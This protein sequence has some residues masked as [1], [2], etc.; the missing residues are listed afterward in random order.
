MV[1]SIDLSVGE[2]IRIIRRQRGLT[3]TELGNIVGLTFQQIQ[4]YERGTNRVSA[5]RLGMLAGA[6]GVTVNAFFETGG[7]G[8]DGSEKNDDLIALVDSFE[9]MPEVLREDFLRLVSSIAGLGGGPIF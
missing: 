9:R 8:A 3:Q 7:I 6:L 1:N 2:R 5:G 4:K